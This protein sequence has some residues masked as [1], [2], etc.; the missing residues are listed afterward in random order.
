LVPQLLSNVLLVQLFV[1]GTNPGLPRV[2]YFLWILLN[3]DYRVLDI[4][5]L[6]TENVDEHV[7]DV[8]KH[9]LLLVENEN[10]PVNQG[11]D[12]LDY[13][14][15]FELAHVTHSNIQELRLKDCVLVVALLFLVS[16]S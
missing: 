1:H 7:A 14:Q 16:T 13:P 5:G 11:V 9:L 3:P 10:F 4:A 2:G 15:F 12:H 8:Q 6:E